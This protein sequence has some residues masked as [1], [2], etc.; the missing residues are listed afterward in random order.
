MGGALSWAIHL[1]RTIFHKEAHV[2]RYLTHPPTPITHSATRS[3]IFP[4]T[5]LS[6]HEHHTSNST[7]HPPR[8]D[9]TPSIAFAD[10]AGAVLGPV[11]YSLC[12]FY[13][14]GTLYINSN[15]PY[16]MKVRPHPPTHPPTHPSINHPPTHPLIQTAAWF[17]IAG[18][19]GLMS[20]CVVGWFARPL[21]RG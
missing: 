2:A 20:V 1:S 15:P 12:T 21:L 4:P 16:P 11:I 10:V 8:Y 18:L 6:H 13:G 14:E 9:L 3:S 19:L 17:S 5:Y 7:T